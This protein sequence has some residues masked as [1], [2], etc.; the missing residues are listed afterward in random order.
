M[1][2]FVYVMTTVKIYLIGQYLNFSSESHRV[3]HK[4]FI[5][6]KETMDGKIIVLALLITWIEGQGN[7]CNPFQ[8]SM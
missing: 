7:D 1:I 6:N 3:S 4:I 5:S 2:S 8:I